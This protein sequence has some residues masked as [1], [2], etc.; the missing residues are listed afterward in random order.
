MNEIAAV[1]KRG[2]TVIQTTLHRAPIGL[3]VSV[4]VHPGIEEFM[5]RAGG[6]ETVPVAASGRYWTPLSKTAPP[7]QAYVI[8][9]LEPFVIE[10]GS[11]V[12]LEA[13]GYPLILDRNDRWPSNSVN[14]SFLRLVGISEGAGITFGV[15]GVTSLSG[16]SRL[17]DKLALAQIRF[18]KEYLRPM[19]F[20]IT[21]STSEISI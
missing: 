17:K 2:E 16:A 15:K 5:R 11:Y 21:V 6:G 13:L 18:Y 3:S 20:E 8:T 10:D 1:I 4:K 12:N 7:L 9:P 19:D 14:I